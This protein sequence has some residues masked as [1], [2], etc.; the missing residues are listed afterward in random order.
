MKKYSFTR[1]FN[2]KN[3]FVL[4][5][6][7]YDI[8]VKVIKWYD[9]NGYDGYKRPLRIKHRTKPIKQLLVHHSGQDRLNPGVMYHVLWDKRNLSVHF[10]YDEPFG[11]PTIYQ[12]VDA[13]EICAHA[14]QMNPTSIGIEICHYPSAWIDPLYYDE[15]R[16]LKNGNVPHQTIE[17][18]VFNKIRTV[19]RMTDATLDAVARLYAGCWVAL[20]Q[21][22]ERPWSAYFEPPE[23]PRINDEIPFGTIK[24]PNEHWGLIAHRHC[25]KN[26]WDP[27]GMEFEL[28]EKKV[29]CYWEKFTEVFKSW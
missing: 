3:T 28:F 20:L 2:K 15:V 21:Q 9:E 29:K 17:Q 26:K 16:N 10:A 1:D 8:G 23:F 19:Y 27:S 7:E 18:P 5:R 4:G 14:G 11:E 24:H 12:F 25:S 6:C 22:H 13:D